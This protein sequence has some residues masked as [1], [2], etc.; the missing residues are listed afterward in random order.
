[1]QVP[2]RSFPIIVT[3]LKI[4]IYESHIHIQRAMPE[5]S[6]ENCNSSLLCASHQLVACTRHFFPSSLLTFATACQ[7]VSF[8]FNHTFA[9]LKCLATS[10]Q[11][12]E[13]LISMSCHELRNFIFCHCRITKRTTKCSNTDTPSDINKLSTHMSAIKYTTGA[14]VWHRWLHL[15]E[16]V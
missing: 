9:I 12:R 10:R 5:L 6:N 4:H 7:C 3:S 16:F 2:V 13:Y 15:P 8:T 11:H 1:M 14:R